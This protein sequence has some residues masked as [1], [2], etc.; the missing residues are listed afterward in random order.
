MSH[1]PNIT[2]GAEQNRTVRERMSHNNRA[3]GLVS[4]T[5][6]CPYSF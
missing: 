2:E 5:V 1:H 3:G 4:V 6:G